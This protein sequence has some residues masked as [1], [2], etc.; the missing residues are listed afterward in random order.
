[1]N[2][3]VAWWATW[4]AFATA[5]SAQEPSLSPL[6]G[7]PAPSALETDL[8]QGEPRTVRGEWSLEASTLSVSKPAPFG[9]NLWF[10]DGSDAKASDAVIRFALAAGQAPKATL[11]FRATVDD[12]D[13]EA[14]SGYGLTI[15]GTGIRFVQFENGHA[16][17][18]GTRIDV[19]R[20]VEQPRIEVVLTMIGP[21]LSA[22]VFDGDSL[23]PMAVLNVVGQR[24]F[25]GQIGV[26]GSAGTVV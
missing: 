24:Y 9:P 10:P 19:E 17:S 20:L 4:C 3:S 8:L 2:A 18:M 5:A 21:H 13:L 16:R 6:V 11:L 23:E 25:T 7:F 26:K 22:Q 15:Q 14:L 1:M 12:N